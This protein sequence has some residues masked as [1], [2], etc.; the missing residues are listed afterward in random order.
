MAA[1]HIKCVKKREFFFPN[2]RVGAWPI[3]GLKVA[4]RMRVIIVFPTSNI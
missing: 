2:Y 1:Q 4:T 3:F